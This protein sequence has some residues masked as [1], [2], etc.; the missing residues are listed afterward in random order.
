[1]KRKLEVI[2][3]DVVESL[4][5]K[6]VDF[7][8]QYIKMDKLLVAL[9]RFSENYEQLHNQIEK[10]VCEQFF[11]PFI[12]PIYRNLHFKI[13]LLNLISTNII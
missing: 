9:K 5:Q 11:I 10:E 6:Y 13:K 1:M 3:L 8:P 12:F 7:I 4:K 2:K